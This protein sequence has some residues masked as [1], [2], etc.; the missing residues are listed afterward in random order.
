MTKTLILL[1][2]LSLYSLKGQTLKVI[3][4]KESNSIEARLH[5]K[6]DINGERCAIIKI[7]SALRDLRFDSTYGITTVVIVEG[8]NGYK[9]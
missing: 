4:F 9:K 2:I 5:P 3:S 6:K 1:F 8:V 7:N